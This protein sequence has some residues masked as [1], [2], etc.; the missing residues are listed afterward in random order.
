MLQEIRE[1]KLSGSQ[2]VY[3]VMGRRVFRILRNVV[4]CNPVLDCNGVSICATAQILLGG[5]LVKVELDCLVSGGRM[6]VNNWRES[7]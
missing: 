1:S 5:E 3:Q 2:P 6:Y 7:C 4:T